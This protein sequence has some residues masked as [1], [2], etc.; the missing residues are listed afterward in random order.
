MQCLNA[1]IVAIGCIFI[2][3]SQALFFTGLAIFQKKR[4][5]LITYMT[6]TYM[7]CELTS[8]SRERQ[9]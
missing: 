6:I 1:V 8:K 9:T 5:S 4:R 3:A 7:T 2:M